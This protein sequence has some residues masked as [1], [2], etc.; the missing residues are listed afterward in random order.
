MWTS[1][2]GRVSSQWGLQPGFRSDLLQTCRPTVLANR[3][4]AQNSGSCI[5]RTSETTSLG[6]LID[7]TTGASG[8]MVSATDNGDKPRLTEVVAGRDRRDEQVAGTH[9]LWLL[10]LP[11]VQAP[12]HLEF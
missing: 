12:R 8:A 6:L 2:L 4:W 7:K 3:S 10:H 1:F 9:R 5:V 11:C